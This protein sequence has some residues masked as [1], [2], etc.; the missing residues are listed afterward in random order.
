[1]KYFSL[2]ILRR[3]LIFAC[4][5]LVNEQVVKKCEEHGFDK[6]C[7]VPLNAQCFTLE[8]LPVVENHVTK[9]LEQC[10]AS[11]TFKGMQALIRQN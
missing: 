7:N 8:V 1:M 6:V 4:S 3:P 9:Q 5:A 2:D 11:D 10:I